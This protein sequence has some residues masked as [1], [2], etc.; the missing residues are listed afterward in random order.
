MHF[1]FKIRTRLFNDYAVNIHRFSGKKGDQP[2]E[3]DTA[4]V[5]G[6][7]GRPGVDGKPGPVGE[8]GNNGELLLCVWVSF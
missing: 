5:K 3:P 1:V 7:A 4:I 2:P 6:D 8:P